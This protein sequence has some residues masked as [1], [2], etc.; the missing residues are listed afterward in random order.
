[1]ALRLTVL[2]LARWGLCR[3]IRQISVEVGAAETCANTSSLHVGKEAVQLPPPF[4]AGC[5]TLLS[6]PPTRGAGCRTLFPSPPTCGGRCRRQRGCL[7]EAE[8]P[9]PLHGVSLRRKRE[10]GEHAQ[11]IFPCR[12]ANERRPACRRAESTFVAE[13]AADGGLDE[14][15]EDQ[16]ERAAAAAVE[17]RTDR[18][19]VAQSVSVERARCGLPHSLRAARAALGGGGCGGFRTARQGQ[20]D[21]LAPGAAQPHRCILPASADALART[22]PQGSRL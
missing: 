15:A 7:I 17:A 22:P 4:E 2:S 19:P 20:R 1:M 12:R 11:R 16:V 18:V 10:R 8:T 13:A 14:A 3:F 9:P 21:P 5:R 6:C